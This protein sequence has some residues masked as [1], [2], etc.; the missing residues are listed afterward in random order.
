MQ[1]AQQTGTFRFHPVVRPD[2]NRASIVRATCTTSI[3]F[4]QLSSQVSEL[5]SKIAFVVAEAELSE[6][7]KK[8]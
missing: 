8:H 2:P 3:D 1:K 6:D 4:T 7:G 5:S